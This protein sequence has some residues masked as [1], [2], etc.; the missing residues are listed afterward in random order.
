MTTTLASTARSSARTS[1]R[2]DAGVRTPSRTSPAARRV[3]R[4]PLASPSAPRITGRT[5]A[6]SSCRVISPADRREGLVLKFKVAA[7]AVVALVGLGVSAAELSSWTQPDPAV[8]Y[9]A[10]DPAW[11]HVSGR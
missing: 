6:A 8:D 11:A 1:V 9:V 4:G 3:L 10:G 2:T 7:V 5:A